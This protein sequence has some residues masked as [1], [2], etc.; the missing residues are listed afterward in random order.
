MGTKRN[1]HEHRWKSK[2]YRF[3]KI[4]PI[5]LL[6]LRIISGS[7]CVCWSAGEITNS[8]F[9]RFLWLKNFIHFSWF[10]VILYAQKFI[11]IV[12]QKK[13]ERKLGVKT[14]S[15]NV[16]LNKQYCF[17]GWTCVC[18]CVRVCNAQCDTCYIWPHWSL[19]KSTCTVISLRM[20]WNQIAS[21]LSHRIE[22]DQ[23][24]VSPNQSHVTHGSNINSD[25]NT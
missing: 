7:M 18:V 8:D 20:E 4:L 25:L 24:W 22:S 19:Y 12:W 11:L 16:N 17:F 14:L 9:V 3:W 21:H 10:W 15:I 5:W 23:N 6:S 2:S 1:E 13:I